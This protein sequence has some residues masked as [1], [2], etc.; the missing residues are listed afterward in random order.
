[1]LQERQIV[2]LGD[3][4]MIAEKFGDQPGVGVNED[5]PNG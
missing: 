3:L 5:I 2:N 4:G 1:V